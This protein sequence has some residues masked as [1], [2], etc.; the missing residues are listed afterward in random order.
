MNNINS[1]NII[2]T[3]LFLTQIYGEKRL[4]MFDKLEAMSTPSDFAVLL[5]AYITANYWDYNKGPLE[6]KYGYYWTKTNDNYR[7]VIVIRPDGSS[8]GEDLDWRN[9]GVRPVLPYSKIANEA[10]AIENLGDGVL[11]VGFGDYPQKAV[12]LELQTELELLYSS[13]NLLTT[14]KHYTTDSRKYNEYNANFQI[15]EHI[16]YEHNGKKYVRVKANSCFDSYNFTLS[17]GQRYH[18]GDYVWVEVMP[19]KWIVDKDNDIAVSKDLLFSGIQFDEKKEYKGDFE[20]TTMYW[21]LNT[22]FI[23]EII[24]T[25]NKKESKVSVRVRKLLS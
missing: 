1:E 19:I 10:K 25:L 20:D 11:V 13:G 6:E 22:Y 3:F 9:F 18:D 24:K 4:K 21:F 8:I 23:K 14:G 12:S 7:N 5:G 17:N 16:E 2:A 15:L